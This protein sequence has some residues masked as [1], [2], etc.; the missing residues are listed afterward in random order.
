MPSR[1]VPG[2]ERRS[3][4]LTTLLTSII[5][6][7]QIQPGE[8]LP[9]ER[10]LARQFGM[11]RL[12]VREG[13]RTLQSQGIVTVKRGCRGGYYVE[14]L[15]PRRLSRHLTSALSLAH[16]S[17]D[18]LLEARLGV[19]GEI[20]RLAGN[21]ATRD[22]LNRLRANVDDTK[23]LATANAPAELR[24]KVHEFHVLLAE[25]AQNPLYTVIMHSI[26][27]VINSYM[28]RLGYNSIVSKKTISEHEAVLE[29]LEQRDAARAETLLRDHIVK[30]E[31]RLKRRSQRTRAMT[32]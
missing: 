13:M 32:S 29:S 24:E 27:E 28:D 26:V 16:I 7:G 20:I 1:K 17:L 15:N 5:Q 23:R 21:R 3:D 30:D 8:R 22:D 31:Q 2:A 18:H 12:V 10:E 4:M 11:G 14:D 9:A 19:E 6:S 25:A